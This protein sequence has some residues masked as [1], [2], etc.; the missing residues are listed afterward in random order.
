MANDQKKERV[1]LLGLR[2]QR[3]EEVQAGCPQEA[4][5]KVFHCLWTTSDPGFPVA[6][7]GNCCSFTA[8]TVQQHSPS[9]LPPTLDLLSSPLSV[10]Q[11]QQSSFCQTLQFS[12]FIR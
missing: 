8:S 5:R 3:G 12:V 10:S 2:E 11:Q 7:P 4:S 9:G 1:P 6:G